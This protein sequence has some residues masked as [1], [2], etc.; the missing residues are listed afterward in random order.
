MGLGLGLEINVSG[1]INIH[2][3]LCKNT[4]RKIC[5]NVHFWCVNWIN[6]NHTNIFYTEGCAGKWQMCIN[7]NILLLH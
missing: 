1:S 5:R 2:E 7:L 4:C 3:N 6:V